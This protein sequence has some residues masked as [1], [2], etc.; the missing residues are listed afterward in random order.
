[1]ISMAHYLSHGA[2]T[3]HTSPGQYPCAKGRLKIV[4][5]DRAVEVEDFASEIEA[6]YEFAFH[7]PAIDLGENHAAGG[8]FRLGKAA[9]AGDGDSGALEGAKDRGAGR[10]GE[11]SQAEIG[12]QTSHG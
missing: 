6:R 8:D 5:A 10:F 2:H 12:C 4:A 11:F 3:L 1:M 9:G 7:R